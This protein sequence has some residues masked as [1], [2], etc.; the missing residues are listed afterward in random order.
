MPNNIHNQHYKVENVEIIENLTPEQISVLEK[1]FGK[2]LKQLLIEKQINDKIKELKELKDDIREEKSWN[3]ANI[4]ALLA[5]VGGTTLAVGGFVSVGTLSIINNADANIIP[6]VLSSAFGSSLLTSYF[7]LL[8]DS[9]KLGKGLK[10]K[11][12]FIKDGKKQIKNSS[13]K[14]KRLEQEIEA[15]KKEIDEINA[16]PKHRRYPSNDVESSV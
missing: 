6:S 16:P 12:N 13:S 5:L 2:S 3:V 11:I 15:L 7:V 1:A 9:S 4:Y 8:N 10:G 14:I